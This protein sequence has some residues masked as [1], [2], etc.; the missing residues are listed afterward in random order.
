LIESKNTVYYFQTDSD[1]IEYL[2]SGIY[3]EPIYTESRGTL[4]FWNTTN[5]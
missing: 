2:R 4:E 3:K 1:C 5:C